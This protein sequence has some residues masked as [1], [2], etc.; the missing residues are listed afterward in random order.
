MSVIG[1]IGEYNPFHEGHGFLIKSAKALSSADFTVSVMSGDFTQRGTPAV[2]NKWKR[3]RLAV[4]E[5][6][7]LILEMPQAFACAG[8][9]DFAKA[10]VRI[11]AGIKVCDYIA[12]GSECGNELLLRDLAEAAAVSEGEKGKELMSY[13]LAEGMSY[14]AARMETIRALYP[15]L[16]EGPLASPNDI[17]GIEYLKEIKARNYN[18]KPLI[19][20]RSGEGHNERA[21]S[22]REELR[23][24]SLEKERLE[25]MEEKYFDLIRE[26]IL[27]LSPE[28]LNNLASSSE[29]LQ[30]KLKQ[31]FRYA[32]N[33][34]DLIK[35][36]KSKGYTYTRI[37]RLLTQGL[38][39]IKK[40]YLLSDVG[41]EGLYIRP[42]AFDEKGAELLRMIHDGDCELPFV[43]SPAKIEKGSILEEIMAVT[44]RASDIYSILQGDDLYENSDFVKKPIFIKP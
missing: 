9:G 7:N 20:E 43:E 10:G 31:E 8:A 12:F 34:D 14:P 25:R 41:D 40:K 24:D 18:L 35:R 28:D 22:I 6:V 2:F 37:N 36:V 44:V 1:I 3:A 17:L 26:M 23:K 38:L 15:K 13:Y 33:L 32:K 39:G 4:E 16:D 30:F 5:G 19:V 27:I 29:G 42:L 21:S 11:L